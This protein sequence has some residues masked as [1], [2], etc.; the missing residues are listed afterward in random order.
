ME[1]ERLTDDGNEK[2]SDGWSRVLGEAMKGVTIWLFGS[3]LTLKIGILK[4]RRY[5]PCI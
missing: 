1:R 4:R 2:N 5:M 3:G